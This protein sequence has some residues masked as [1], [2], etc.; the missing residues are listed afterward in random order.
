[1]ASSLPSETRVTA[2]SRHLQIAGSGMLVVLCLRYHVHV[3]V[4][5]IERSSALMHCYHDRLLRYG[6]VPTCPRIRYVCPFKLGGSQGFGKFLFIYLL[7]TIRARDA[8]P[9]KVATS[10]SKARG[11]SSIR[12]PFATL[13]KTL[14]THTTPKPTPLSSQLYR[15]LG[16]FVASPR[17]YP[18]LSTH[19]SASSWLWFPPVETRDTSCQRPSSASS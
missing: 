3:N 9:R 14:Q 11:V 6:R 13:S 5:C 15:A 17:V 2:S 19:S 7:C 4:Q 1:V 10:K 12:A 18:L 16:R 8:F